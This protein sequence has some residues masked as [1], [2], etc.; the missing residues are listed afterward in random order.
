MGGPRLESC[1]PGPDVGIFRNPETRG[2]QLTNETELNVARCKFLPQNVVAAFE[3]AV[4]IVELK[5]NLSIKA[6]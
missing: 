3:G 5:A 6:R 2:G 1:H 4:V